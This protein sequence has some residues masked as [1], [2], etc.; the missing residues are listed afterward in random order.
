[1]SI[2]VFSE[3][4][5]AA[6][7]LMM[8]SAAASSILPSRMKCCLRT[9]G[10]GLPVRA[11]KTSATVS[12]RDGGN[13]TSADRENGKMFGEPLYIAKTD[14]RQIIKYD[15]Y[16]LARDGF[17]ECS[18]GLYGIYLFWHTAKHVVSY[19]VNHWSRL[20]TVVWLVRTWFVIWFSKLCR[21]CP[22]VCY[23][24]RGENFISP[25]SWIFFQ[26][27]I[28]KPNSTRWP[29]SLPYA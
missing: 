17:W 7:S 4:R 13:G 21:W 9:S 18:S 20:T 23:I 29:H 1:M 11:S 27:W 8:R 28:T 19:V 25:Y 2:I 26:F 12:L 6:P 3:R 22:L 14:V 16:I 5:R 24:Y 15:F 10:R